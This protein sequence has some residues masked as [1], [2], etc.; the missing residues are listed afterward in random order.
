M[1]K[2]CNDT[3]SVR[4]CVPKRGE[5]GEEGG[6]ALDSCLKFV[7]GLDE[8]LLHLH[9]LQLFLEELPDLS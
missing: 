1:K 6:V 8:P 9:E 4:V 5:E 2:G 3:M 7:L